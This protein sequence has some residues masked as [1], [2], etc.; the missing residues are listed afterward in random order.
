M[1][2]H[3]D[4]TIPSPEGPVRHRDRILLVGSC[5]TQHIG[6]RL[7]DLK[8]STLQNPNGILFDAQSVCSSLLSYIGNKPA[9]E[10]D[11]FFL[12]ELWQS[13]QHHS[14][15]SGQ[16]AGEVLANINQSRGEAHRFLAEAEWLIITLGTAFS[17]RLQPAGEPVAN[18][19]RAPAQWFQKHMVSIPD[20]LDTIEDCLQQL[21]AFNPRLKT[22]FTISPVRHVRE[23]VTENNRSKARLIEAVHDIVARHPHC[24]YFP[25]YE[26][27]IDVLRDYRF[28]D[29]DLVHPNYAAT[30]YVFDRFAAA[31]L[32]P[33]ESALLEEIQK[34]TTAFK[35]HPSHPG[36]Q[37][38]QGFLSGMQS[39]IQALQ[40]THGYIDFGKETAYFKGGG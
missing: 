16:H 13:W 20:I 19:H 15:F 29:I 11:L 38:H 28:Y 2:F 25:A 21:S 5:F 37:A 39:R 8:F 1:K 12:N 22:I 10:K 3:L 17:Y 40:Q 9:G 24:Y 33:T 7:A 32:A 27:V 18:C 34:I 26:L 36:T 30:E 4:I 6:N 31:Y 35:H 23:G 14:K